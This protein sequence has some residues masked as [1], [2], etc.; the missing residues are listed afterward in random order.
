MSND[1][2]DWLSFAMT[3]VSF[4]SLFIPRRGIARRRVR[5]TERFRLLR[6]WGVEW[7]AYDR[8]DDRQS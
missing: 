3:A 6:I 8:D 2:R 4:L 1:M 7:T 5:R